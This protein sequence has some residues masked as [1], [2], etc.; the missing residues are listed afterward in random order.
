M[1]HDAV[2]AHPFTVAVCHRRMGKTVAA[3]NQLIKAAVTSTKNRPHFA[4]MG[5]TYTQQKRNCWHYLIEFTAKIPG[6]KVNH[7][8]LSITLPNGALISIYGSD[9][10]DALRGIYLDGL[11]LDEFQDHAPNL[12]TEII[13]PLRADRLDW[14]TFFIVVPTFA[15]PGLL[16]LLWLM[17][18]EGALPG[19]A[20]NKAGV[21][22]A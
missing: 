4:I 1:I 16:L 11:V 20:M 14:V 8:E 19:P 3:V 2:E 6:V 5:P 22:P 12:F 15:L 21:E 9:N 10:P 18:R 13:T 17:S 7:S